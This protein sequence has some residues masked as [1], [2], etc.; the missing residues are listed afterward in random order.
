MKGQSLIE[1]LI[2][3]ALLALL[4]PVISMGLVA[5]REGRPQQIRRAQALQVVQE[6]HDAVVSIR[7]NSWDDITTNGIY[8]PTTSG[9]TWALTVGTIEENGITSELEITDVLRDENG[10]I[11]ESGGSVDPSTKYITI[12]SSWET[13]I[14]GTVSS[15][16][17]ATRY[18]DNA[19]YMQTTEEDFN[20]GTLTDVMVTNNSG[21]EITLGS[22]GAG[23]WCSPELTIAALDL[24]KS[25]A[26]NA[27]TAIEGK[28]FAATGDNASGVAFAEVSVSNTNPPV[29]SL[30]STFDGYKTNDVF[31][32]SNYA[33]IVTDSN[34]KEIV[35][36]SISG[37]PS[38]SGYFDAS[39]STDAN[40]IFVSGTVGYMTQGSTLRTFDLSSK[41]GSRSELG[42]ISLAGTGKALWVS[43]G[44]VYVAVDS[45]SSELQIV[46][47]TNPSSLSIAGTT[48]VDSSG[49]SDIIV[50]GTATRAYISADSSSGTQPEV[51]ILD[52]STKTGS[53][54][55]I[56][57][58]DTGSMNPSGLTI[59]PGN[60]MIVVGSGGEEYQ[61]FNIAAEAGPLYCGG[62][63]IDTGING[64]SSVL[65]SDGDAYSY[66]ITG[67]AS[68]E[69]KI[70]EGGPGGTYSSSGS[71]ESATFDVGYSSAFNRIIPTYVAP[72]NTSV[73]FHIAVADAIAGSCGGVT[74]DFVGPDGTS[75]TYYTNNEGIV[76]DHNGANYEN[77]AQCF[78]YRV[79]LS[80][81]DSS[82]TPILEELLINYS[83]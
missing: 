36:I 22:G 82:S 8:H 68:E 18:L 5:S 78:R 52:I 41:S 17:Y 51:F 63:D 30:D 27:V 47:A 60:R 54:S 39:G 76:F 16:F 72:I 37:T 15:S 38:E 12:T 48:N 44:Y 74:Y 57:T 79:F 42:S 58:A 46:N 70:I 77:P 2:V 7:E 40:A 26:A 24:P 71:Y 59:V 43:G 61:V 33:Y 64:I 21:G 10:V 9:T 75:G 53:R 80:T 55:I 23:A 62:I 73:Q 65:E 50:N 29:A 69:F 3:I 49:V 13:P 56:G 35:I 32:E 83:P 14:P 28:A 6:Y 67:D 1:I 81:S 25:G 4:L 66:I 19:T 20:T 31:G 11:V 45:S 34:S